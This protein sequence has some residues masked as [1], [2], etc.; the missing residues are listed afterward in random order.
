MLKAVL[1]DLDGTLYDRDLLVRRLFPAQ[2][3]AFESELG[4]ADEAAFVTRALAL[5]DHGH[6]DKSI[7]YAQIC[8]EIGVPAS[9]SQT[10]EKDFWRRYLESCVASPDTV[11]TLAQL[12]DHGIRLGVITNG[13]A[14]LQTDKLQSLGLAEFFDTILISEVEGVRKPDPVIFARALERCGVVASEAAFVGDNPEADIA[15]A[16]AAGLLAIWKRIPYWQVDD[17]SVLVVDALSE[18]LPICLGTDGATAH[19]STGEIP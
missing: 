17:E 12:R 6:G 5:D 8:A 7:L 1:F 16:R 10:L 15:G 3:A 2:F 4:G 11:D 9:V 19:P 18:I 13:R 14:R